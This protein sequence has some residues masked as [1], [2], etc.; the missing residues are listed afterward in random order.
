MSFCISP[1]FDTDQSNFDTSLYGGFFYVI[2]LSRKDVVKI[3]DTICAE[4]HMIVTRCRK[5][6]ERRVMKKVHK[7]L[8]K[9]IAKAAVKTACIEANTTCNYY[10]YQPQEPKDLKR[11]RKF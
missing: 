7:I 1:N 2:M 10:S 3:S 8:E 11:L 4:A 6:E 9:A 5:S